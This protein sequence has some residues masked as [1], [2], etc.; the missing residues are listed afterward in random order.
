MIIMF[1]QMRCLYT[2]NHSSIVFKRRHRYQMTM[3]NKLKSVI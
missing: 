2:R 1:V 3:I